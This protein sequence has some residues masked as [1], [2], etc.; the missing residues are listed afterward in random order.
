MLVLMPLPPIRPRP[1]F[2]HSIQMDQMDIS[3]QCKSNQ[4]SPRYRHSIAYIKNGSWSGVLIA[5]D[6]GEQVYRNLQRRR[7]VRFIVCFGV[8]VAFRQ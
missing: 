7:L 2:L 6:V 8:V 3:F 4:C 1:L 5:I